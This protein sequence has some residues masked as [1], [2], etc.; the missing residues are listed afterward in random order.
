MHPT[1]FP[2]QQPPGIERRP[3]VSTGGVDGTRASERPYAG[4]A[5]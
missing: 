5:A 4:W 3:S 1:P 2:S